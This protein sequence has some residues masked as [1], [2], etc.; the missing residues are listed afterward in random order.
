M[1]LTQYRAPARRTTAAELASAAG[2]K[3]HS[4]VNLWYGKAGLMLFHEAPR[5]LPTGKD[6]RP[7]FSFTLSIEGEKPQDCDKKNWVWEMR[8]EVARG[9]EM[10]AVT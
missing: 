1:L 3:S 2:Y 4:A 6:G 9:L 7:V 8:P 5:R 10:A